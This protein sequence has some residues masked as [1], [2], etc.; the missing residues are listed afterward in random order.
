MQD[1]YG[2]LEKQEW[3]RTEKRGQRVWHTEKYPAV[4]DWENH[5]TLWPEKWPWAEIEQA[6]ARVGSA[7]AFECTPAETPILMADW[8]EKPIAKVQAGDRVMGYTEGNYNKYQPTR[9]AQVSTVEREVVE[10]EFESGTRIRCTA[11]HP[12]LVGEGKRK[13]Y[14]PVKARRTMSLV[15]APLPQ[16]GAEERE[17]WAYLAGII[18]GEGHIPVRRPGAPVTIAQRDD[19]AAYPSIIGC[20]DRL[21]ISYNVHENKGRPGVVLLQLRGT[22]QMLRQLLSVAGPRFGKAEQARGWLSGKTNVW[23]QSREKVA[24]IYRGQVE[25]AYA[26]TTG[27]KNYIAWG[28]RSHNT[29]YQQ[30]PMPEGSALVTQEVINACKDW[31]RPGGKGY[32]TSASA[33]PAIVRVLSVDPSPSKFNG[34]VVGDL[35]VSKDSFTFA[36]M[37][38]GSMVAGIEQVKA[39]CDRLMMLYKPD[40]FIFEESGFLMWMRDDP[41]FHQIKDRVNFI[42]HKTGVNKNHA[43]YGVQSLAGDFEQERISLPYGDD[44]GRRMTEILVNEALQYPDGETYD[45]LM[46]LWFVKFNYRDLK[47]KG[48]KGSYTRAGAQ[49]WGF[50]KDIRKKQDTADQAYKEWHRRHQKKEM[51]GV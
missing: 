48:Q 20:L 38:V 15:N 18:D 31:N 39:E 22:H 45:T 46:A 50:L 25:T 47:P 1:L 2:E 17:D 49:P 43:E 4:L 41:W 29:M 33:L 34:I 28:F 10:V 30:N 12:W 44:G 37:H 32:R 23:A 9:V 16:P 35:A 3:T 26:L 24:A 27:T 14:L 5:I 51:S 42:R 6:Y 19:S 8:T 40:Y 21:G 11:D 13:R 36:V 7:N